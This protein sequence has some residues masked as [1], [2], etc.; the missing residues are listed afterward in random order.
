VVRSRL[1]SND[2]SLIAPNVPKGTISRLSRRSAFLPCLTQCSHLTARQR[3]ARGQHGPSGCPEENALRRGGG[4]RRS[5]AVSRSASP[6]R[7]PRTCSCMGAISVL[8]TGNCLASHK[9]LLE[10]G[11]SRR[12][13]CEVVPDSRPRG[14]QRVAPPRQLLA[15]GKEV[16]SSQL[17]NA[18]I[19]RVS[20]WRGEMLARVRTLTKRANLEGV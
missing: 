11:R 19:R 3:R 4:R 8:R 5:T 10:V 20:D 12:L 16:S 1:G 17:I 9:G 13:R 15:G 14:D 7:K 18:R 2:V 6:S